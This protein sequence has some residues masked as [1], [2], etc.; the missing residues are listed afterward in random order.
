MQ[1]AIDIAKRRMAEMDEM[2]FHENQNEFTQEDI[3]RL[4]GWDDAVTGNE[5]Y[6]K[7]GNKTA[8]KTATTVQQNW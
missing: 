1:Q 8:A 4:C 5:K 7:I 6:S 3:Y 2:R